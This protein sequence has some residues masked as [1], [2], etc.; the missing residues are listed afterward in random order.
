MDVTWGLGCGG[1]GNGASG[2]SKCRSRGDISDEGSAGKRS[3]LVGG[4]D[5]YSHKLSGERSA[6]ESGRLRHDPHDYDLQVFRLAYNRNYSISASPAQK[7]PVLLLS[8]GSQI[9]RHLWF[10]VLTVLDK[11]SSDDGS[12]PEN[13][14]G[15]DPFGETEV[16]YQHVKDSL[17]LDQGEPE[18]AVTFVIGNYQLAVVVRNL[19]FTYMQ[20]LGPP[21][22]VQGESDA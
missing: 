19:E 13:F 18:T 9:D 15:R 22:R 17:D 4:H 5:V 1:L 10:L 16:S 20:A 3:R 11:R 21:D 8:D 7:R 6:R 14:V 12:F 2:C